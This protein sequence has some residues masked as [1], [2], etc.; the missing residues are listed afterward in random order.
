MG[1]WVLGFIFDEAQGDEATNW[2]F[3]GIFLSREDAIRAFKN[4]KTPD[5]ESYFV[6]PVKVGELLFEDIMQ[7]PGFEYIGKK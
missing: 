6:A 1:L 7:I 5:P 3:E 4:I 2:F